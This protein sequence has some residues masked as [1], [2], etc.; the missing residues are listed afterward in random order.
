MQI[1]RALADEE[2]TVRLAEDLAA[3]LHPG[4]VLALDG[5]LGAGKTTFARYLIRAFADDPALEV[6]SPSF[7]LVQT[8]STSRLS[9]HHFDFYRLEDP[10]EVDETGFVDAATDGAC[11]VEWPQ[12][13]AK[14]IPDNALWISF[15]I[16]ANQSRTL[17]ITTQ[18]PVDWQARLERTF[19]VRAFL[20]D[21][22]RATGRRRHLTGDASTRAYE[23]IA[24]DGE[25][26]VLMNAAAQSDG[27]PIRNGKPYSRI[28]HLAESVR[29]FV[30]IG[31]ALAERHYSA[32]AIPA[33]DLTNGLLLLEDLGDKPVV[34]DGKPVA[35]RYEAAI[36]LLAD[37]HGQSWPDRVPVGDGTDH[38][39]PR[40]D[41]DAFLI[42]I[43]LYPAWYVPY[44]AGAPATAEAAS[45]FEALWKAAIDRLDPLETTW[46]LR[47]FHS[48][49]LIWLPERE[50]V[51]RLGL[52][53]FQD[54]LIGPKAYDVASLCQDARVDVPT[55]LG[56]ALFERYCDRRSERDETFDRDGFSRDF[57]I[58]AAHRAT[59]VLGIFARLNDRD[60]KPSYLRHIPRLNAYLARNLAHPDLCELRAWYARN[61]PAK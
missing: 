44:T 20:A 18:S 53:D 22:N 14:N 59:K 61:A 4:D 39:V 17:R 10:D 25:R 43:G 2:G 12:R 16:G 49:N 23:R 55:A 7:T 40:Y 37:F 30:A 31:R 60:G 58:L 45:D 15:E 27:P 41:E 5:D 3:I 35:V 34:E 52:L 36:D 47:D 38:V 32:P 13:A 57:A 21:H 24:C 42:E 6:P 29:P 54:T 26:L 50:G 8:Y 46:V 9:L 56:D 48:P 28:A 19:A 51:R 11:L 33:A 1:E